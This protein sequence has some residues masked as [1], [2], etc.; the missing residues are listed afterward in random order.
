MC[1]YVSV[2]VGV[3]LCGGVWLCSVQGHDTAVNSLEGAWFAVL[4]F[5]AV[6]C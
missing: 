3:R 2:C 1:A 6:V 4:G 5:R